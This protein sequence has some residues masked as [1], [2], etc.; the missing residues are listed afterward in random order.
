MMRKWMERA[1]ALL[2]LL[3]VISFFA[4]GKLIDMWVTTRP[5]IAVPEKGFV[6]KRESHGGVYFVSKAEDALIKI[7]YWVAIGGGGL[8]VCIV[9]VSQI[10]IRTPSRR[11]PGK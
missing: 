7:I 11:P 4:G 8:A 5:A 3:A 9:L 1:A 6:I 2:G 10:G